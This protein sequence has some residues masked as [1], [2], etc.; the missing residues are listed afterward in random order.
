MPKVAF[1]EKRFRPATLEMIRQANVILE[2]YV[3][4]GLTMNLRQLH[5]Q[6]VSRDVAGYSNTMKSYNRLK[7]TMNDG[8]W[9]GLVDWDHLEDHTRYLRKLSTWN[10][11]GDII[12]SAAVSFR[13][14]KWANQPVRIECWVE[15]DALLGVIGPTCDELEIPYFSLRGY[16][17]ASEM[18]SARRRIRRY[19]SGVMGERK[20]R[21][22]ILHLG[23]HDPSGMHITEDLRN[24]LGQMRCEVTI[25]RLALTHEQIVEFDLPPN[26]AKETDVRYRRY[27][28]ETGL[29]ESWELD[30]VNPQDLQLLIEQRVLQLRD[31][32]LWTVALE[33]QETM[34][35]QLTSAAARWEDVVGML[36]DN[37]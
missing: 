28:A 29:F 14:D 11:P 26:P 20:Q 34:R 30:A 22:V 24:R 17:S 9:A 12:Q 36:Q 33:E 23:D 2:E 27:V 37:D 13:T 10:N 6:F 7:T 32:S 19:T 35:E 31:R 25:E 18:W 15:K 8:R 3:E 21:A 5:Y 1:I 4:Q 16:P